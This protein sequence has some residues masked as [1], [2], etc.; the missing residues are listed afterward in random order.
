MRRRI[1]RLYGELKLLEVKLLERSAGQDLGDLLSHL[2][3]IEA[4]VN[5]LRVP[6]TFMPMLYTLRQHI[7]M[8]RERLKKLC[9]NDGLGSSSDGTE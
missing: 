6:V 4:C 3:Q 8:D 2:D 5:Q 7:D 1:F 9:G